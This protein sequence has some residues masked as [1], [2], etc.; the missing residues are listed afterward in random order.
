[1]LIFTRSQEQSSA[2]AQQ[3]QK[4]KHKPF[5]LGKQKKA[6]IIQKQQGCT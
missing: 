5:L 6:G 2:E 3:E 1:M 4:Q